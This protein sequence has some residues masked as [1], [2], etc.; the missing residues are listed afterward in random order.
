MSNLNV[1]LKEV[2]EKNLLVQ[3]TFLSSYN[4]AGAVLRNKFT[5]E[6]VVMGRGASE[7]D[8][9]VDAL[10]QYSAKPPALPQ[11]T[12]Q[13]NQVLSDKIIELEAKLADAPK[14]KRAGTAS[15]PGNLGFR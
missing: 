15:N 13:A 8:A 2:A 7:Y 4:C 12:E 1:P 6:F 11:A 14:A 3:F 10:K 5:N 9:V